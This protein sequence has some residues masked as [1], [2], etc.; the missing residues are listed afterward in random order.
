MFEEL[1]GRILGEMLGTAIL[2]GLAMLATILAVAGVALLIFLV[3]LA[4]GRRGP[5]F[6]LSGG[7]VA[8]VAAWLLA[9]MLW[10]EIE[11]GLME[12]WEST[13][14]ARLPKTFEGRS[15]MLRFDIDPDAGAKT[16]AA[17]AEARCNRCF[18]YPHLLL[19]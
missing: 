19:A 8:A 13:P 12:R 4:R 2:A 14:V 18:T 1:I 11:P 5:V 15:L 10:A 17:L 16:R 9:A 3:L 6:W 7:V